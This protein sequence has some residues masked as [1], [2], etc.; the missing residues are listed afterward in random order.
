ML[1]NEQMNY[2][3]L[4]SCHFLKKYI[5]LVA[6]LRTAQTG[7]AS[8]HGVPGAPWCWGPLAQRHLAPKKSAHR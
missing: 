4:R 1:T 6:T 2:T 3:K 5:T 7:R 8:L